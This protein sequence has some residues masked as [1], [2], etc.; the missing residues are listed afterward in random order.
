MNYEKLES[1]IFDEY[2]R[3]V[4][5]PMRQEATLHT[6]RTVD[7]I[8][9]LCPKEEIM[10]ARTAALLHDYGKYK[11]NKVKDHAALSASLAKEILPLYDYTEEETKYICDVISHHSDKREVHDRL[12]EDLKDADVLARWLEAP[13]L[14]DHFRLPAILKRI[15]SASL[16]GQ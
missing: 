10:L 3:I 14:Y 2:S 5:L 16:P 9:I 8:S 13:T 11:F 4:W 15:E 7:A 1:D 6:F 12:S